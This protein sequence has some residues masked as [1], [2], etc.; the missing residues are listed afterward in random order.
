[1]VGSHKICDRL[2]FVGDLLIYVC[3]KGGF[4]FVDQKSFPF[5]GGFTFVCVRLREK[6]VYVCGQVLRYGR[7]TFDGVT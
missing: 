7:F 3:G 2:M 4:M 5:V 6:E 1:M